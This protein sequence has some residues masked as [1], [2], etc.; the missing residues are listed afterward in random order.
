MFFLIDKKVIPFITNHSDWLNQNTINT[1]FD[2][3]IGFIEYD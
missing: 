2:S 3:Y 1:T